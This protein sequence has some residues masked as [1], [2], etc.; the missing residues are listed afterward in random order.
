MFGDIYQFRP[1]NLPVY[2]DTNAV[3]N[4]YEDVKRTFKER[5]FSWPWKPWV[6]H[7]RVCVGTRPA[8]FI[9]NSRLLI[10]HPIF[11]AQVKD[12]ITGIN[13]PIS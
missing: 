9:F 1:M 4:V 10:C 11:W 5:F 8:G 3:E 7:K 2:E 12:S 6:T 13:Y